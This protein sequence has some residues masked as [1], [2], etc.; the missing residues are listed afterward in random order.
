[1][2]S[3]E[4]AEAMSKTANS[5]RLAG[6]D[7]N[8]LL[9]YIASVVEVTQQSASTV[10]TSFKSIF[11]RFSKI[12]AGTFVDE[13][14]GENLNEISRVLG[15]LNIQ[16]YTNDGAMRSVAD[17]LKDVS[18]GWANYTDVEKNAIATSIAGKV[19]PEHI[20]IYDTTLSVVDNYIG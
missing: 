13:E 3:G 2:N 8:T 10:G 4:L 18:N 7:M 14:T 15:K 11:S 1:M 16:L 5:A 9:G 20:V 17:V 6:V 19:L 12:A